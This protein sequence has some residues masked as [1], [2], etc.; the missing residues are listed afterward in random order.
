M[1]R[2]SA[3]HRLGLHDIVEESF[4]KVKN[5]D[6]HADAFTDNSKFYSH[7]HTTTLTSVLSKIN[8][9]YDVVQAYYASLCLTFYAY[10]SLV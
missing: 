2:T 8:G 10:I 9:L 1:C 4:E 6:S 7:K 3:T 5:T